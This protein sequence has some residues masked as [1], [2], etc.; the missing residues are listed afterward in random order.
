MTSKCIERPI[1]FPINRHTEAMK[2]LLIERSHQT[3]V[4]II[5]YPV[6]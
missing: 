3:A 6:Y 4:V 2:L 1:I 5:A